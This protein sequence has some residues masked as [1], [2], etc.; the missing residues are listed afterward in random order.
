MNKKN[1]KFGS[2]QVPHKNAVIITL[3]SDKDERYDQKNKIK[4]IL[5]LIGLY[6]DNGAFKKMSKN[7]YSLSLDLIKNKNII[8]QIR[9]LVA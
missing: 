5:K 6:K 3:S 9:S 2:C 8:N 7:T 1:S 4:K